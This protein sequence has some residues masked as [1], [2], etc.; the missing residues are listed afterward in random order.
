MAKVRKGH[1]G[2]LREI[3]FGN[4]KGNINNKETNSNIVSKR[5]TKEIR[6]GRFRAL[7]E[8]FFGNSSN[9][10]VHVKKR[11]EGRE[12]EFKEI[13]E[14]YNKINSENSSNYDINKLKVM[15]YEYQTKYGSRRNDEIEEKYKKVYGKNVADVKT[16]LEEK[17]TTLVKEAQAEVKRKEVRDGHKMIPDQEEMEMDESI[18]ENMEKTVVSVE[19]LP[20]SPMKI[21]A[22]VDKDPRIKDLFTKKS[23]LEKQKRENDFNLNKNIELG[24]IEKSDGSKYTI[25]NNEV[26]TL[27]IENKK[28]DNE[29]SSIRKEIL[30]LVL[31]EN[32]RD[33]RIKLIDSKEKIK[34]N[35]QSLKKI[36]NDEMR[37]KGINFNGS[38]DS[39]LKTQ[40]NNYAHYN[41][42]AYLIS[43]IESIIKYS[44]LLISVDK[45]ENVENLEILH[46]VEKIYQK[47]G[48]LNEQFNSLIESI[49]TEVNNS[50]SSQ[51]NS[52]NSEVDSADLKNFKNFLKD[53]RSY[54]A[55]NAFANLNQL[56]K[57]F[58]KRFRSYL[59]NE[60]RNTTSEAL[61][62]ISDE[63]Y[64]ALLSSIERCISDKEKSS[65]Q[66]G[67]KRK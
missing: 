17:K 61:V 52:G 47:F 57:E 12:K 45:L 67:P 13:L 50:S 54:T 3:F 6:K 28:I 16:E 32:E 40:K 59:I 2:S 15:I 31:K 9:I 37:N 36:C 46:D 24:I 23:D 34:T 42:N 26:S 7:R 18:E 10:D 33:C 51:S 14:I 58:L 38:Y 11:V 56:E 48:E 21:E 1:L 44:D 39:F 62:G 4:N 19:N 49:K 63:N 43:V 55:G 60:K 53:L 41:K 22:K 8:I 5:E 27:K 35:L 25:D 29:I 20:E 30:E 65:E 64:S 66:T